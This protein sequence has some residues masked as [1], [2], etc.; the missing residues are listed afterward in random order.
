MRGE[1]R[2]DGQDVRV[3]DVADVREVEEV[4]VRPQL[5]FGLALGVGVQHLGDGEGVAFAD[6]AGRPQ[7]DGQHG[8]LERPVGGQDEGFGVGL[9][10]GG[11]RLDFY[12]RGM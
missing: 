2:E 3:R 11:W 8:V 9:Y 10:R 7:R 5:E 12:T 6:D 1:E 4:V